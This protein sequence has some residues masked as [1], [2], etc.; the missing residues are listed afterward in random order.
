MDGT[1]DSTPTTDHG[2]SGA[3]GRRLLP[4]EVQE[5]ISKRHPSFGRY[6]SVRELGRGGM[7]A[8]FKAWDTDLGRWVALKVMLS[9]AFASSEERERFLREAQTGAQFTHPHIA[10]VYEVGVANEQPFIAM[11]YIEGRTLNEVPFRELGLRR[12]AEHLRDAARA[13]HH[14][15]EHKVIHRDVKPANLMVAKN[16]QVFVLDFGLARDVDMRSAN[17]LTG[18]AVG[19]PAYMSPEQARGDRNIRH[20][21]DVYALGATL[22]FAVT[23]KRPFEGT[24]AH[25][26]INAVIEELP[27]P[28]SKRAAHVPPD[29]EAIILKA[30]EKTPEKRYATAEEFADDLQRY[31]LGEPIRARPPS[32]FVRLLHAAAKRKAM[33]AS[34]AVGFLAAAVLAVTL[35]LSAADR[36]R[37]R[38]ESLATEKRLVEEGATRQ[39]LDAEIAA[40]GADVEGW[41]TILHDP[42][43][44]LSRAFDRLRAYLAKLDAIAVDSPARHRFRGR[45][46]E[47]LGRLEEAETAFGKAQAWPERGRVRLRL[48]DRL[49]HLIGYMREPEMAARTRQRE[50]ELLTGA[51]EDFG[52]TSDGALRVAVLEKRNVYETALARAKETEDADAWDLAADAA[53]TAAQATETVIAH[54]EHA[55]RIRESDLNLAIKASYSYGHLAS[56]RWEDVDVS[57][58]AVVAS[59]RL[60]RIALRL[61]P[62]H[63]DAQMAL[64]VALMNHYWLWFAT[65]DASRIGGNGAVIKRMEEA[66]QVL[67]ARVEGDDIGV[68]FL[69][70]DIM[71]HIPMVEVES[72]I[73]PTEKTKRF[74]EVSDAQIRRFPKMNVVTDRGY[75]Y[76]L[77]AQGEIGFRS[78]SIEALARYAEACEKECAKG[79]LKS[80]PYFYYPGLSRFYLAATRFNTDDL[81]GASADFQR[82]VEWFTKAIEIQKPIPHQLAYGYRGQSRYYLGEFRKAVDDLEL[83]GNPG[84]KPMIEDARKRAGD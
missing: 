67:Q 75:A 38:E 20:T 49:H 4:A 37:Q 9:G 11:Q 48:I 30:M 35:V 82:A 74:L 72:G 66:L 50:T 55:L 76:V 17:S 60:A 14:A 57:T 65:R 83:S 41:T 80:E 47:L 51:T 3:S 25:S 53:L 84:L 70:C 12:A 22:Y 73:D 63:R 18:Y 26:I 32:A 19:T 59:E 10:Q 61:Q 81:L 2:S 28:P 44:P 21:T 62:D 1:H 13:L 39:K 27:V 5:A 79:D 77:L 78:K 6:I 36:A 69:L 71:L 24:T 45:A 58:P 15:H 33:T 42:P 34:I 16:G 43:Q 29:L 40:L 8:V 31:I 7:G 68:A 56:R 54:R 23:G 46:L 52:R 64:C